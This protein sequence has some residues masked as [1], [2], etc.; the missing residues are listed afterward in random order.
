MRK[1]AGMERRIKI[2]AYIS[3]VIVAM[4][5]LIIVGVVLAVFLNLNP[6]FLSDMMDLITSS[7]HRHHDTE[8]ENDS[9]A[10]ADFDSGNFE[11]ISE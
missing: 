11:G 9:R 8:G 1:R 5:I 10:P 4:V 7:H 2:T 6:D 3:I